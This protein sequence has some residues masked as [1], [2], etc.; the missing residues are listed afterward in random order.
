MRRTR[1]PDSCYLRSGARSSVRSPLAGLSAERELRSV[2]AVMGS[3]MIAS[4]KNIGDGRP[5]EIEVTGDWRDKKAEMRIVGTGQVVATVSRDYFKMREIFAGQQTYY[6]QVGT[7]PV[8]IVR[9]YP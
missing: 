7:M 3:R 4:F 6:V 1:H 5:V 9:L 8:P 2:P